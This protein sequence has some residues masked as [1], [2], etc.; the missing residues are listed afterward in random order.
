MVD[1]KSF[2]TDDKILLTSGKGNWRTHDVGPLPSV[3][4]TDGPHGLRKQ[5]DGASINDSVRA[6]CFPTACCVASSWNVHNAK[7]VAACIAE[8]AL[9]ENVDMVLGPG[10]NIKRSPLCGRNF[11][12]FSEDPL[13][14]GS[15]GTAYVNGMQQ[16]GV[17]SCL[18]HFAVNSQETRRMT[19]DAL[20]DE[21]ALRE[22]YLSAFEQ[23]VKNSQPRAV[24]ACYNKVNGVCGTESKKLLTDILRGEWHFE[25]MVVS[26]WGACYDFAKA[27]EAGMDLEMPEDPSLYHRKLAKRAVENGDLPAAALN[28]A[29]SRVGNFVE[30]CVEA[31]G[32]ADPVK[33]FDH[34][35]VCR[36]VA[37]D[38]AVLLKNEDGVLPLSPDADFCVIGALAEYPRFQ[39]AGSSHINAVCNNFPLVLSEKG[40]RVHYAQ[41]YSLSTDQ[42]DEK[43]QEEAIAL[44]QKHKTVLF[45]GGL[46]D[47]YEGE[48]YDRKSFAIPQNQQILLNK[49]HE[50]TDDI[51]FVGFGGSPFAMPWLH[52]VRGMLHMYLGGQE[53]MYAAYDLIFGE[54][55]PGGRLAETYPYKIE[56]TPCFNYFANNRHF[57]EHRESIFVGYRY[58]NTFGV[59]VLFPFGYGL[60]YTEFDYSDLHISALPRGFEVSLVVKNVGAF[61]GAEVVQLYV[62]NSKGNLM[63]AK[64]ELR[65][66]SKVYLEVGQSEEVHFVLSERDFSVFSCEKNAFVA[67]NGTYGVSVCKNVEETILSGTVEVGFGEDFS[68]T[69]EKSLY[70]E[71][72]SRTDSSF[73]VSDETFFGLLGY[74]PKVPQ[75]P[76]RREFTLRHTLED[77][78]PEV[79]LVRRVLKAADKVAVKQSPTKSADDPVA[80]MISCG[81]RETP[82]I[83]LMSIG[84]IKAKY[85]MFLLNHANKK[86]WK[87]FKALFGKID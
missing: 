43:L 61:G 62:D 81:A 50:V 60:S 31:R 1:F 64:R 3:T 51:V 79:W 23:T 63:R 78:A 38:S 45:F 25:G 68:Q 48:G 14:A 53:V 86:H 55:S 58:Y 21:R 74:K 87:A 84:G 56:D 77:M 80:Q 73:V 19:V 29:A 33:K 46:T 39:G 30:K 65:A 2:E 41:G 37:A 22:I 67:V 85:V 76:V 69:D 5:K 13:L 20:V 52:L 57:D 59:P 35:E 10:I 72:F 42:A 24:M 75:N 27:T 11:E 82:L 44:A 32:S 36:Q 34:R 66:F 47:L 71:F 7:K 28:R 40:F 4:M 54:I 6:T 83:S 18:K 15:F 17:A 16:R 26:D 12:Y 9:A 8:E 49:L 70:P